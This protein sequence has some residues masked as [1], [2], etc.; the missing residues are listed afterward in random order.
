MAVPKKR[1]SGSK[2]KIRNHVWKIRSVGVA[3]RAFSLAQ[4]VLTGRSK[5]FYYVTEKMAGKKDS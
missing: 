2:K 5:S 1:T 3:S 4:S